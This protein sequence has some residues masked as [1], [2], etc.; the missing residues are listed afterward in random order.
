MRIPSRCL[1]WIT[2]GLEGRAPGMTR[3]ET[4]KSAKGSKRKKKHE[5]T[6]MI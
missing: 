6:S 4:G 5:N 2:A 3:I 1:V